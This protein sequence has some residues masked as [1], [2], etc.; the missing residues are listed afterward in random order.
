MSKRLICRSGIGGF[1][2]V[3]KQKE[4]RFC[5]KSKRARA[6]GRGNGGIAVCSPRDGCHGRIDMD[7]GERNEVDDEEQAR[8]WYK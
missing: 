4:R 3:H 8:R 5:E 7:R 1:V 6:K 2:N